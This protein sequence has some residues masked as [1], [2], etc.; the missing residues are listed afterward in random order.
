MEAHTGLNVDETHDSSGTPK[1]PVTS[2][3]L[4]ATSPDAPGTDPWRRKW[5]TIRPF[6]VTLSLDLG[7]STGSASQN[8][9]NTKVDS[10]LSCLSII[11][12]NT[13][14][15]SMHEYEHTT[16]TLFLITWP[17]VN[18]KN[19][20]QQLS[21]LWIFLP[22]FTK[23]GPYNFELYCFKVGAF[24]E[25]TVC[26]SHYNSSNSQRFVADSQYAR[27]YISVSSQRVETISQH[28]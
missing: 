16:A 20:I 5:R 14:L 25:T 18:C 28:S 19:A 22:N 7:D 3:V 1:V 9:M 27:L 11:N 24:F 26:P 8:H 2:V 4:A 17:G 23:T 13:L 12:A 6:H 15:S 10:T 21:S